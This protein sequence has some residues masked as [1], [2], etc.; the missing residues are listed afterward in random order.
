VFAWCSLA[1]ARRRASL[2]LSILSD[3]R[4][5]LRTPYR[6]VGARHGATKR[7]PVRRHIAIGWPWGRIESLLGRRGGSSIDCQWLAASALWRLL[8]T[9]VG[10]GVKFPLGLACTHG[11]EERGREG[12]WAPRR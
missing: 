9:A 11:N 7:Y 8:V 2:P 3:A 4:G 12:P 6:K 10:A 5:L 1:V